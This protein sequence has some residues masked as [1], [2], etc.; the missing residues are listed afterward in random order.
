MNVQIIAIL[1]WQLLA[2]ATYAVC[3]FFAVVD[4]LFILYCTVEN[5]TSVKHVAHYQPIKQPISTSFQSRWVL[6]RARESINGE[7]NNGNSD[8]DSNNGDTQNECSVEALF[9]ESMRVLKVF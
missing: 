2:S 1:C 4:P 8:A 5:T 6:E 3:R 9:S 7:L